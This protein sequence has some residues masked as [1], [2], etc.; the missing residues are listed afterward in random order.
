MGA[1]V[2]ARLKAD[3]IRVITPA[4]RSEASAARARAAGIEIVPLTEIGASD[5]IFS[6]VPPGVAVE[7]AQGVWA[8]LHKGTNRPLYIDWNAVSPARAQEV[9]NILSAAGGRFADGGFIGTPKAD[10]PGPLLFASGPDAPAL[11]A[12]QRGGVRLKILDAPNGAASALKMSYAGITKGTTALGAAMMLAAQRAGCADALFEELA[13]SQAQVLASF[14]RT[15][16][17]MFGKAERFAPELSEIAEFVG[18]GRAERGIYQAMAAFYAVL[19]EDNKGSRREVETLD[20][21]LRKER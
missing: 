16:P 12:L 15:I 19:G 9:E 13:A 18:D 2:D 14:R 5:F 11:A 20:F 7:T 17:D 6:I 1:A 4:G 3:G 10:G 8:V 21:M